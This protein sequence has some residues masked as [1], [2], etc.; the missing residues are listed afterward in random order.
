MPTVPSITLLNL[1]V[2]LA[3]ELLTNIRTS[4]LGALHIVAARL[5]YSEHDIDAVL[6]LVDCAPDIAGYHAHEAVVNAWRR[7]RSVA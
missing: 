5:G 6:T 1:L 3:D 4:I 2:G 7:I